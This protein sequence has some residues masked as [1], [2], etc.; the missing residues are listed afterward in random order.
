MGTGLAY[1]AFF[2][3]LGI[4][5]PDP[6][7]D[8]PGAPV[9][10]TAPAPSTTTNVTNVF[11]APDPDTVIA[12]ESKAAPAIAKSGLSAFNQDAA[13]S[14]HSLF[15]MGHSLGSIR[16]D[17]IFLPE[18]QQINIAMTRVVVRVIGLVIAAICVWGLIGH[19]F[20]SDG[21]EAFEMLVGVPLWGLLALSSYS[22]YG[23][24]MDFFV[25]LGEAIT[26]G[27]NGTFG[28]TL[29]GDF[30]S[31]EGLGLFALFAGFILLLTILLFAL[32]LFANT[33]FL[34]F[35]LAVAPVF[36]F[37][38]SNRWTQ[39]WGNNWFR[40]VPGTAG[41][42]LAMMTLLTLGAAAMQKINSSNAFMT[43]ALTFG[44]L[45]ALPLVRRLF[46]LESHSIGG[47]LFGLAYA[48]RTIRA[49]RGA[50]AT[51]GPRPITTAGALATASAST[52]APS[53]PTRAPRWAGAATSKTRPYTAGYRPRP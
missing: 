19:V 18:V 39:Q 46:G 23:M 47:S 17:I 13:G 40:M 6:V 25:A 29:T 34:A 26:A 36:V 21:H 14:L 51:G 53:A 1:L 10:S 20:G 3:V 16:K 15:D 42:L 9:P 5:S 44:I 28:R 43:I 32:Q 22:W 30:W 38:K 49:L 12:T 4:I 24:L 11:P 8:V 7:V 37:C 33:A 2:F 50:N 27:A 35:A 31:D 52:S 45:L 41:D 48:A